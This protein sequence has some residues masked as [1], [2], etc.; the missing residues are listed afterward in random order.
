MRLSAKVALHN[1]CIAIN[2]SLGRADL[3]TADLLGWA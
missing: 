2:R 3:A 1:I